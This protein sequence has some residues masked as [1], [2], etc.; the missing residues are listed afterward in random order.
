MAAHD[1]FPCRTPAPIL[2]RS[3]FLKRSMPSKKTGALKAVVE[4]GLF[5]AIGNTP[6]TAA[7][8]AARC[9]CP[10]RGIRILSDNLTILGF[11]TKDES[12]YALSPPSA[13]FLDQKS[14]AYF[15]DAVKFLLAPG[16][17]PT[18][19]RRSRARR[20]AQRRSSHDPPGRAFISRSA[21][22][23]SCHASLIAIDCVGAFNRALNARSQR[24]RIC[25]CP[26]L[27]LAP[28]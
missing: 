28:V 17:P 26:V 25:S 12:R 24:R 22:C 5:T 14:P 7:E 6:S 3:S 18:I 11:L 13:V 21:R 19:P 9:Q 16:L 27:F 10:E 20:S 1:L 23:R 2:P 4:L 15:G 8:I